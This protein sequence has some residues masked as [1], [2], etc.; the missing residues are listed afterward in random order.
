MPSHPFAPQDFGVVRIRNHR[1]R[2]HREPWRQVWAF[3][4]VVV[5]SIGFLGG[6]LWWY[7]NPTATT[8]ASSS[9]ADEADVRVVRPKNRPGTPSPGPKESLAAS[10]PLAQVSAQMI[11]ATESKGHSPKSEHPIQSI[12][13]SPDPVHG[14]NDVDDAVFRDLF[15]EGIEPA[16]GCSDATFLRRVYLDA[17]GTLPTV[18]ET[19]QFLNNHSESKR[20]DLIDSL[21][22]RPEFA[23]YWAMKWCD[24]LR[25]KAEFP[26]N[27]WPG[28][29]QAYH[30]WVHSAIKNNL[31]FDEFAR[32]LLTSSGSNFRTP[33]VNFY[34]ALQSKEPEAI[35]SAVALTFLCERTEGWPETRIDG[36]ARF[37]SKIGYKPT[38]EWKEEIV[39][40]D[41]LG[42]E[43]EDYRA[44][45][46][47][48][49][50]GVEVQIP[51]ETDPRQ[52]FAAWLTH[53]KNPW[54]A[55]AAANRVWF[56][57]VG[58]GIVH[59][60][61]DVR[62]DNPPSNLELL[63]TLAEELIESGYD[64]KHLYRLILNSSA[65]QLSC[66]PPTDD[67]RAAD[68]FAF[69]PIQRLDAEVLID[70][71][72]QITETREVYMSIIP[73]PFTF[74]PDQQ[75]AIALPD[76]SI[77][78]SFLEM[79]GRPA[80]D[81]GMESE[82]NNRLTARQ[83]L[84]LL[85]SNHIQNKINRG[86]GIEELIRQGRD[87]WDTTELLYL[88]IL[89]RQPSEEELNQS[90]PLCEDASGAK[91]LAWILINSDEFL[92]RH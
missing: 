20:R 62:S 86:P 34:R 31:P 25:V 21:L 91:E 39:Y 42:A 74:L 79:F 49:P 9:G 68:H 56:W 15:A 64:M 19:K 57:L 45:T 58:R 40:F 61:D 53:K 73:E 36:M 90:A 18:Y 89:S 46:A 52:V 14:N 37:F 30:H 48:Y 3:T 85:N 44:L 6:F 28:A 67:T 13:E 33:Q 38:G 51:A 59:P 24:V 41:R 4:C 77:T 11:A 29:A 72:C 35:A 84:H 78:S 32:E 22:Q 10:T 50:S 7:G 70:A 1:F 69:Y 2:R 88:A 76:G 87:A 65:Y 47:V 23:D 27:L 26:I 92:F 55:R 75:R 54:F 83:A 5:V 8:T 63:N 12:F 81:T 66:L 16:K 80:R 71:I 60:P 82:R 17:I 43:G